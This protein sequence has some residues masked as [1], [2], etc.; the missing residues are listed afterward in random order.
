MIPSLYHTVTFS[1]ARLQTE[2]MGWFIPG[3]SSASSF[4]HFITNFKKINILINLFYSCSNVKS[5]KMNN[6]RYNKNKN[7]FIGKQQNTKLYLYRNNL[8]FLKNIKNIKHCKCYI[9]VYGLPCIIHFASASSPPHGSSRQ[10]A[11]NFPCIFIHAPH[12]EK[13][14]RYTSSLFLSLSLSLSLSRSFPL[15]KN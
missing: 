15:R 4:N 13:C 6:I 5:K 14:L 7:I 11:G 12:R 10:G 1:L 8:I 9:Q 3:S 2:S